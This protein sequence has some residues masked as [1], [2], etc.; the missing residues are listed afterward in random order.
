MVGEKGAELRPFCVELFHEDVKREH[1][2]QRAAAVCLPRLTT[3]PPQ[4]S[5]NFSNGFR[6]ESER[7]RLEQHFQ[8]IASRYLA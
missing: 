6:S 3:L 4:L 2:L 1:R 7:G 5:G 8:S